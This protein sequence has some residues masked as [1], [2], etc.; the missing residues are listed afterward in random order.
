M[1]SGKVVEFKCHRHE[2]AFCEA[3]QRKIQAG[4]GNQKPRRGLKNDNDART[5]N[6]VNKMSVRWAQEE[7][8]SSD[9]SARLHWRDLADYLGTGQDFNEVTLPQWLCAALIV[10]E[11]IHKTSVKNG[12]S[13]IMWS[14][15]TGLTYSLA[16]LYLP[17]LVVLSYDM[18]QVIASS[19]NAL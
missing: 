9:R 10:N 8:N 3:S 6:L 2:V 1:Y 12:R 18:Q 14:R 5:H 4:L 19:H 7:K 17:A 15:C 11:P 16:T 13:S